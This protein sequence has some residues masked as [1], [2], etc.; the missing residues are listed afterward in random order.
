[1]DIKEYP[2]Y[3]FTFYIV[4]IIVLVAIMIYPL[5]SSIII[6][7]LLSIM[8]L[9]MYKRLFLRVKNKNIAAGITIATLTILLIILIILPA[10]LLVKMLSQDYIWKTY[11][12]VKLKLNAASFTS[13]GIEDLTCQASAKLYQLYE[14]PGVK[15]AIDNAMD[16]VLSHGT[17]FVSDVLLSI[18]SFLLQLF[19]MLFTT[20]FL[21]RDFDSVVAALQ[22]LIPLPPYYSHKLILKVKNT[23]YGLVY[24]SILVAFIQGIIATIGYFIFGVKNAVVYG[25][26]TAF[27]AM[28]PY[29]GTLLVWGPLA[30]QKLVVGYFSGNTY[31]FWTGIGLFVYGV[32][33]IST[34]DNVLKPKFIGDKASTH[35]ILI[36]IG[37]IGGAYMLGL[38]GVLVG[39]IIIA[40]FDSLVEFYQEIQVPKIE[41]HHDEA[42]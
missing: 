38:P 39:P 15:R 24:G 37:I 2:K 36:L 29:I 16:S 3:F 28:F 1:M 33:I 40:V 26:L 42:T 22:R 32:L 7:I 10:S 9:P 11:V 25:L 4:L 21:I 27:S 30:V 23:L 8:F 18:P 34:I 14:Q 20:F 31:V 13:C 41:H 5:F 17:T 6:A 35:P 19:V 12:D